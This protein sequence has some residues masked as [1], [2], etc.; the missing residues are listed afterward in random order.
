MYLVLWFRGAYRL[1]HLLSAIMALAAASIAVGELTLMTTTEIAFYEAALKIFHVPIFV[2][3][4][5]LI[6]VAYLRLGGGSRWLIVTIATLWSI[7]LVVNFLSPTGVLYLQIT[8]LVRVQTP[9]GES[10]SLA[11]GVTNPWKYLTDAASVL[12]VVFLIQ[13][14]LVAWRTGLP[15]RAV[16]VGGSSLFF[17]LLAGTLIPMQDAGIL[18]IPLIISF[19]FLAIVAALGYQLVDEALLASVA[20]REV[21]QLGRVITLGETVGGMAHE[22]N[23]PLAAILSNA[24]AA[25]RFLADDDVD[26]VEIR[27]IIDDIISDNKR[28]SGIIRG[29]RQMLAPA[30]AE[31]TV[32]DVNS[33]V[34]FA[35]NLL[36]GELQ[37]QD[38]NVEM[39]LKQAIRPARGDTLQVQQVLLNLLLNAARA[40][41][42]MPRGNR[43][44]TIQSAEEN[45]MVSV[46]VIDRGRGIREDLMPRLFE[47]FITGS[48]DG[49]GI[50][51][52]ICKRIVERHGGAIRAENRKGGG[53]VFGFTLPLADAGT[54][55]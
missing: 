5:S 34:R 23:Q 19:S 51:L 4:M 18:N 11:A 9:W 29:V 53:A 39:D 43:N 12:T 7:S 50:G 15:R 31:T 42:D 22:I 47:P 16:L 21:E 24:Q 32:V 26:L 45:G 1:E 6:G 35:A 38:I 49:L 36:A 10:Y 41:A 3:L 2:M 48:K 54:R 14:S 28:A 33:A 52:T 40:V 55:V 30:G 46:S 8:E 17:I 25:R 37:S 27:E 44:V 13:A 20:A